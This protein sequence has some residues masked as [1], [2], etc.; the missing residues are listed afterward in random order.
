MP[1]KLYSVIG[2]GG[3]FDHFHKG[4]EH[5]LQF[6][7]SLSSH[8][9][10]G[11]TDQK[12]TKL[13]PYPHTIE[14]FSFRQNAV[15]KYCHANNISHEIVKLNDVYG[16]TITNSSIQALCVTEETTQGAAAI[17]ELRLKLKL[18]ELPVHV[19]T[20]LTDKTGT[21]LASRRIRG[22]EVSRTGIVYADLLKE[23]VILS[24]NQRN[25]FAQNQGHLVHKPSLA[26][27]KNDS[28]NL[29][30]VVGDTTL[31]KFVKNKWYFSLGIYDGKQRRETA[32]SQ[33]LYN[34]VPNLQVINEQGV[35]SIH[36]IHALRQAIE[37]NLQLLFV[38]GEEDLATVALVLLLPLQ[39]KIYYGQP[40]QGMVEIIV[41]EEVKNRFYQ[42][43]LS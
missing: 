22:G 14:N 41:S 8:L 31:E 30:L 11:V 5:F 3:T 9:I 29:V 21:V 24:E 18:E 2:L 23:D 32:V 38:N 28:P 33:Y 25:F 35:I 42:T 20:M 40:D 37:E 27:Q 6:A 36:L 13:K 12:L 34:L 19:A 15:R 17:N 39:A 10:I 16:P 1:N 4:H 26:D 7:A 43:L